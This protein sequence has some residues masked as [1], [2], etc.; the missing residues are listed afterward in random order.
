MSKNKKKT[1][2]K[3]IITMI[4]LFIGIQSY[5]QEMD[6]TT[7][8]WYLKM[9][10]EA[11]NITP[12]QEEVLADTAARIIKRTSFE[13]TDVFSLK[14]YLPYTEQISVKSQAYGVY[15]IQQYLVAKYPAFQVFTQEY[16]QSPV[17]WRR[18]A[19]SIVNKPLQ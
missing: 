14:K 6:Q 5:C 8:Q 11:I 17:L 13:A 12:K 2:K 18:I 3:T 4:F 19:I 10:N 7:F 16:K 15:N 1:M 9:K